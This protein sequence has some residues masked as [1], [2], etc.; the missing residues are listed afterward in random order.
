MSVLAGTLALLWWRGL[1]G[2]RLRVRASILVLVVLAVQLALILLFHGQLPHPMEGDEYY[3]IANGVRQFQ[4]P[5]RFITF[6]PHRNAATWFNFPA[7]WLLSGAWMR[8]FG[9]GLLQGRFFWLLIIWLAVPFTFLVARKLY[10]R[11]AALAALALAGFIPLQY[12]HANSRLLVATVTVIAL[13]CWLRA[14]EP[15][16]RRP[17]LFSLLCGLC[18]SLAV[19]GHVYGVVFPLLFLVLHTGE[20]LRGLRKGEGW[21][22]TRFWSFVLG[23]GLAALFW[24]AYHVALP[25]IRWQNCRRFAADLGLGNACDAP[26]LTRPSVLYRV[27]AAILTQFWLN[28]AEAL[29]FVLVVIAKVVAWP[30]D[31]RSAHRAL[32][33]GP[34]GHA[35]GQRFRALQLL[36]CFPLSLLLRAVRRTGS[37]ADAPGRHPCEGRRYSPRRA[38]PA[39]RCSGA[40]RPPDG[41]GGPFPADAGADGLPGGHE[42]SRTRH[43]HVAPR[44]RHRRCRRQGLLHGDAAAPELRRA[45]SFPR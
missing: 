23:C 42:R 18:A 10:G 35:C 37:A 14:R 15:G 12:N 41:R 25:G 8:V 3:E 26:P 34:A 11:T 9:A 40:L 36:F 4:D 24:L 30:E 33:S 17:G 44:R 5:G 6:V 1:W 43:R 16:Q 28:P 39:A 31:E 22:Q 2:A 19:E 20:F 13:Y 32:C 27:F 21:R 7:A 38:H 45:V 29:L